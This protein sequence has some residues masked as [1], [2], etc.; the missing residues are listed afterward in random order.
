MFAYF[1]FDFGTPAKQNV[2]NCARYILSHIVNQGK[3]EISPELKNLYVK[4]CNY[5]HEEPKLHDLTDMLELLISGDET[6]N[7]F[8]VLDGLDE[9]PLR[10]G[11]R[12]ELLIWLGDLVGRLGNKLHLCASSRNEVDIR[13]KLTEVEQL[14]EISMEEDKVGRDIVLYVQKS[15]SS[16]A[17]LKR[18]PPALK[19]EIQETLFNRSEGMFRWVDCQ[20][21]ELKRCKTKPQIV[22]A[23]KNL[24]SSLPA[25]YERI[26]EA[27]PE[28]DVEYAR[29]ALWWLITSRRPLTVEEL[30][31]A[32]VIDLDTEPAFDTEY[33]FFDA[34]E[35]LLEILGSLVAVT[36]TPPNALDTSDPFTPV[37]AIMPIETVKLSHFSVQEY[38]LSDRLRQTKNDRLKPFGA[39]TCQLN[40]FL[41][42]SSLQYLHCYIESDSRLSTPEDP[43]EFPLLGYAAQRWSTHLGAAGQQAEAEK[44][45]LCLLQE[46]NRREAWLQIYAP[47]QPR[48]LLFTEPDEIGQPMHYAAM[49]GLDHVLDLLVPQGCEDIDCTTES[50][51]T[52]LIWAC[53][54]RQI[55]ST[56]LL[57]KR[58]ADPN[59]QT[60]GGRSAL[61]E[62]AKKG[63]LL[64][65]HYLV[66]AGA[67]IDLPDCDGWT[68][69]YYACESNHLEVA[70]YLLQDR[71]DPK[72]A[73]L[74]DEQLEVPFV[75]S[76]SQIKRADPGFRTNS[77]GSALHQVAGW[78]YV[79]V[80]KLLLKHG[81]EVNISTA[82]GRTP[83]H[84]AAGGGAKAVGNLLLEAGADVHATDLSGYNAREL[85][86]DGGHMDLADMLMAVEERTPL[87][88]SEVEQ[89]YED[90]GEESIDMSISEDLSHAQIS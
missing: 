43:A 67:E 27:I 1:Y 78:G 48:K 57:I 6:N 18:L 69:F 42:E 13:D 80:V 77:G 40:A 26:L 53:S 63:S 34:R 41:S 39:D 60:R 58:G 38:F 89:G 11:K 71:S 47:N 20:L 5:G 84:Q 4:K 54:H 36:F 61:I 52:P 19:A 68:P 32:A 7:L 65:V 59:R 82:Y 75:E 14:V 8:L 72:V 16:H 46:R 81:A 3:E 51:I 49:L 73:A 55:E 64:G 21:D 23:L 2:L 50:G 33:R 90:H 31:E 45:A 62:A 88:R 70:K 85:A 79:D 24:P 83:L 29:R 17:K 86:E 10:D 35:Q 25:T 37:S 76:L 44:L 28:E 12:E 56:K 66:R 30:A 74:L 9:S 15:L 22:H 87:S